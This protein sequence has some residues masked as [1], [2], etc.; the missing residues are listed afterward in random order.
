MNATS[1]DE[2][3]EKIRAELEATRRTFHALLV[4]LTE[5]DLRKRSQNPGWTNGEILAHML[6]G[7]IILRALLP[8]VRCWGRFPKA[9]SKPFAQLLNAFTVPFNGINAQGARLQARLFTFPRIGKLFDQVYA[10]VTQQL[11][12]IEGDEWNRGMYYPT[13]W[14]P[15]FGDFMTVEDLF[16]Y[17]NHHFNFHAKQIAVEIPM[18]E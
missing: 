14:D 16:H 6:F 15:N 2:K 4:I 1:E 3:K 7:L 13:H 8:I 18:V 10:A 11:N 5:P 9:A 17:T 12:A